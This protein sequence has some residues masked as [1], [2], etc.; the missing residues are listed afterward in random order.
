MLMSSSKLIISF[1]ERSLFKLRC[2][3]Y[4][5]CTGL[6]S[7]RMLPSLLFGRNQ[8]WHSHVSVYL[9]TFTLL[10]SDVVLVLDFNK[11]FGGSTDLATKRHRSA[12]LHTP[13]H[14]RPYGQS[15]LW[16][17]SAALHEST[18][19]WWHIVDVGKSTDNAK[20]HSLIRSAWKRN[21][22]FQT[23]M[24]WIVLCG[25]FALFCRDPLKTNDF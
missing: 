24:Q 1:S 17:H 22:L 16:T 23:E 5:N 3:T 7:S 2:E 10:F 15:L 21:V 12:E 8:H 25:Y 20:P 19:L 4:W 6:L 11:N 13:I 9:W 14:P 18:T